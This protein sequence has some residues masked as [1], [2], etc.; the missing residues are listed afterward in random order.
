MA[1]TWLRTEN[2]ASG[3]WWLT[4]RPRPAKAATRPTTSRRHRA[5]FERDCTPGG[6][7]G[8]VAGADQRRGGDGDGRWPR[9]WTTATTTKWTTWTAAAA[10]GVAEAAVAEATLA[11]RIAGGRPRWTTKP[12]AV[13]V[14]VVAEAEKRR[15]PTRTSGIATAAAT[16]T[17]TTGAAGVAVPGTTTPR[18][19]LL[20]PQRRQIATAT[21]ESGCRTK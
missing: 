3:T 11:A 7:G 12:W 2:G 19:L 21:V 5:A 1:S 17:W 18:P 4:C 10:V 14:A 16:R 6:G 9:R 15:P 20:R 8:A 13:A